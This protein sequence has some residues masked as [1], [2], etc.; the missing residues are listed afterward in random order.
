MTWVSAPWRCGSPRGRRS[1]GPPTTVLPE[2][3]SNVITLGPG[4]AY[5][6]SVVWSRTL[7]EKGCP[8]DQPPAP[9]GTYALTGRNLKIVSE[10]VAFALA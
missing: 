8:T 5:T 7:S 6:T 2:A 4:K 9:A 1:S 10:P 3:Q